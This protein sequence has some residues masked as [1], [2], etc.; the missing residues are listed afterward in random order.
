[1][2]SL[3]F[4]KFFNWEIPQTWT[5]HNQTWLEPTW[6]TDT[7][8]H[9]SSK[10]ELSLT[11]IRLQHTRIYELIQLPQNPKIGICL[12]QNYRLSI[13][14]LCTIKVV[15]GG[16]TILLFRGTTALVDLSKNILEGTHTRP[17]SQVQRERPKKKVHGRALQETLVPCIELELHWYIALHRCGAKN[18]CSM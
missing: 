16:I 9:Q 8:V 11:N 18:T 10:L 3:G 14:N 15:C 4:R 5:H 6:L 1:M 13:T 7:Q 12:T 17:C 2:S